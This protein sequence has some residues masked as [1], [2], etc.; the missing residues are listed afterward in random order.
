MKKYFKLL[1]IGCFL[2]FSSCTSTVVR[3]GSLIA[4]WQGNIGSQW[5]SLEGK[6]VLEFPG[7]MNY[8][9]LRAT[10]SQESLGEFSKPY[11]IFETPEIAGEYYLN[12]HPIGYTGQFPPAFE[13][14]ALR[15]LVLRVPTEF[16]RPGDNEILIKGFT[17]SQ[18]TPIKRAWVVEESL[19]YYQKRILN[20]I[21]N[22]SFTY[23]AA[24]SFMLAFVYFFQFFSNKEDRKH[25]YFA[26]FNLF[27]GFY[28]QR[29]NQLNG[30]LGFLLEYKWG[31]VGVV[32]ASFYL[33][34]FFRIYLPGYR[35]K[36]I[37]YG[38]YTFFV[39]LC[40]FYLLYPFNYQE[41]ARML[42]LLFVPTQ[43][44][45]LLILYFVFDAFRRGIP[46][47][48]VLLVGTAVG[49]LASTHDIIA[50]IMGITPLFWYQ[51]FGIF[52]FDV[53]IFYTLASNTERMR[54][55]L[56]VYSKGIEE[57]VKRRTSQLKE[58]NRKLKLADQ[59]KRQFLANISHEMRTPLNGIIGFSEHLLSSMELGDNAK[60]LELTVKESE[61]LR[62]LINQLLDISKIEAGKM[63]LDLRPFRWKEINRYLSMN[64]GEQAR[65][66]KLNFYLKD[67]IP[68]TSC[69]NGDALRLQQILNNLIG[70]AV[71]FTEEGHISVEIQLQCPD[72]VCRVVFT[73]SD[74][75][76]G[77]PAHRQKDIFDSFVQA[78]SSTTR[79]F[80]GSGLGMSLAK[81][82]IELM[83]GTI[84]LWSQ[85]NKGTTI[86]FSI[87]LQRSEACPVELNLDDWRT[88]N[89]HFQGKK[90]LI[91]ED[92][93]PNRQVAQLHLKAFGFSCD[94][95]ENG[96]VALDKLEKEV[97]DLILMDIHMPVMDGLTA[98]DRIRSHPVWKEIPIIALTADAYPKDIERFRKTGMNDVITKPL[99]RQKLLSTVIRQMTAPG[100][101]APPEADRVNE[102]EEAMSTLEWA[103]LMEEYQ[104]DEGLIKELL[105]TFITSAQDQ[106]ERLPQLL[107]ARDW[108]A[109]H[110]EVHS[111]KGGALNLT[112]QA[113]GIISLKIEKKLKEEVLPT[114]EDLQELEGELDKLIRYLPEIFPNS[115]K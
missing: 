61:N 65:K 98:T 58:A 53:T 43:L 13:L 107:E 59:A 69:F 30:P 41:A 78:D 67:P 60:Y 42:A 76:I 23:L 19:A 71:K 63:E 86:T 81:Q 95:A 97:Y 44:I 77:I 14:Q 100:T 75:G 46:N 51:G 85:E 66:K 62:D 45:I 12:G 28:F 21:N 106:L 40:V 25:L 47:T 34:R 70:N 64:L 52:F 24:I 94:F 7:E 18:D 90:V 17:D 5:F 74:T 39:S 16:I 109:A 50:Y 49:I 55:A 26:L 48:S 8:F 102:N 83:G 80:G 3:E 56:Q 87:E 29:L 103:V 2:A 32:M 84:N 113:L 57:E 72:Q 79:K 108:K 89:N 73:I 36:K 68:E 91:V 114:S 11:L 31:K 27:L 112:A 92:Y 38:I 10:L 20:L 37:M 1:I 9:S 110:R 96:Q 82:L 115:L 6:E 22:D 101:V 15:Y 104:G 33:Y 111:I 99:K 4:D 93:P 88:E 54:K 35:N 105:Q